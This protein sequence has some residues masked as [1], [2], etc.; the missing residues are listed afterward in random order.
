MDC[1]RPKV[2]FVNEYEYMN[3]NYRPSM[4]D[5]TVIIPSLPVNKN[6]L[7]AS[8]MD[9]HGGKCE[10][11]VVCPLLAIGCGTAS[12]VA[13][14]LPENIDRAIADRELATPENAIRFAFLATDMECRMQELVS[15][16]CTCATVLIMDEQQYGKRYLLAANIGDSRIVLSRNGVPERLSHVGNAM[17]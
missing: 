6:V 11:W 12:Y 15:S 3:P 8:L 4:E 16:G 17:E 14:R 2:T 7:F 10:Y 9:G 5:A 13:S 1:P